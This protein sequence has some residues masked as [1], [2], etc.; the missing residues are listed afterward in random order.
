MNAWRISGYVS[1]VLTA[2]AVTLSLTVDKPPE[3][4]VEMAESPTRVPLIVDFGLSRAD[5]PAPVADVPASVAIL[6]APA[7]ATEPAVRL[8]PPEPTT[9]PTV[10]A[11]DPVA[12][13]NA[14]L[15][16]W[17]H[18]EP[19][20]EAYRIVALTLGWT[21]AEIKRWERFIVDDV[22][23]K[24]SGGCWRTMG[25][26]VVS[27]E[28]G[29][30]VT[31]QGRGSDAGFF[32]LTRRY[33]YEPTGHLCRGWGICSASAIIGSPFQSMRAGLLA[34]MVDG[35]GP[36]CYPDANGFH[37]LCNTVPRYFR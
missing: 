19:A 28:P 17:N 4:Q 22:I 27:M 16:Q 9:P 6:D 21:D 31:R 10:P 13:V 29:C 12:Y 34:V 18:L 11:F 15:Y 8:D 37:T 35:R 1:A 23:D 30:V 7:A 33:W 24:E 3:Q 26:G 36:W 32:Q 2:A 14:L 5:E 20:R 25:G